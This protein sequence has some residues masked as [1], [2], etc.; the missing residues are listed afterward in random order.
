MKMVQ[1]C[2]V[3][4]CFLE[5]ILCVSVLCVNMW[6]C[7]KNIWLPLCQ[8]NVLLLGLL[9]W[10]LWCLFLCLV[11]CLECYYSLYTDIPLSNNLISL[12]NHIPWM[13][14]Q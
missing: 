11:L 9:Q 10:L 14:T 3:Y 4:S 8:L 2:Q 7:I 5:G 1:I 13:S 6:L 12:H